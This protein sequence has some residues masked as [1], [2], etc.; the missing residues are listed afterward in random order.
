MRFTHEE[1]ALIA[2][3]QRIR[4]E[5]NKRATKENNARKPVEKR[6]R[7]R[8]RNAGYLQFLRR[9]PCVVCRSAGP[10]DAAHLRMA[11]PSRGKTPTGMQVKPSDK[12]AVA[13][14]RTCH[15][16]QHSG[17]EARF[18]SERGIDPF[19]AAD[20]LFSDYN[21]TAPALGGYERSE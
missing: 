20:R 4:R 9:Q 16:V 18:W 8:E 21:G 5:A 14:C 10:N 11:S 1:R 17:S 2:A 3:A 19:A 13:M 12:Y 7:G 6:N 15:T